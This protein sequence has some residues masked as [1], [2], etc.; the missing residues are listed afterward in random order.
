MCMVYYVRLQVLIYLNAE[1]MQCTLILNGIVNDDC[2]ETVVA[3]NLKKK[4][5]ICIPRKY[6]D[7]KICFM[8]TKQICMYSLKVQSIKARSNINVNI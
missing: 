4:E 2:I 3:Y 5:S 8:P 1:R 6:Q 7:K